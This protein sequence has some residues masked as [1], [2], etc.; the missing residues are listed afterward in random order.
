MCVHSFGVSAGHL[1][2]SLP[3]ILLELGVLLGPA[4]PPPPGRLEELQPKSTSTWCVPLPELGGV[5]PHEFLLHIS[6]AVRCCVVFSGA[7]GR[8]FSFEG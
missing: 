7:A 8:V 5:V 1:P 6:A 4:L 2:L 3:Q